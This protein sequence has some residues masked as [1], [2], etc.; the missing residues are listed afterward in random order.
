MGFTNVHWDENWNKKISTVD[1]SFLLSSL[2]DHEKVIA[3]GSL[4]STVLERAGVEH[5]KL[6]HPSPLNRL[7]NDAS[8]IE[9]KLKECK[10]WLEN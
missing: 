10:E 4:P 1:V 7:I 8:Y 5:F 2:D 6:P 9:Q 3:L